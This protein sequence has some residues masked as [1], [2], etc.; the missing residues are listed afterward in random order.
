[1]KK[2]DK[3]LLILKHSY[4][5]SIKHY[6]KSRTVLVDA[7]SEPYRRAMYSRDMDKS[8]FDDIQTA[9]G[10]TVKIAV[11]E[12]DGDKREYVVSFVDGETVMTDSID[13]WAKSPNGEWLV[14]NNPLHL[15]LYY[16]ETAD[17]FIF[18]DY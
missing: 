12:Y 17:C 14:S 13:T 10:Q 6:P 4:I 1:M 9:C 11:T 3:V 7:E 15:L 2:C 5:K 8:V 18:E 16:D